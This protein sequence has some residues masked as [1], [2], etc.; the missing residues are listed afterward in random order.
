MQNRYTGDIGDYSKLGSLLHHRV[1]LLPVL[2]ELMTNL[3]GIADYLR[4]TQAW[5]SSGRRSRA[6]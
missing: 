2:R 4:N 6:T 1:E 5:P 3:T